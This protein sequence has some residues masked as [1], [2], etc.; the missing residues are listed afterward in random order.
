M[1]RFLAAVALVLAACA[2]DPMPP[3]E[4]SASP[5]QPVAERSEDVRAPGA[6]AE[7]FTSEGCSSCPP[8]DA[9]LSELA[10]RD[11]VI[12]LSFHV[13]YWNDLG[14]R[15]PYSRDA[16]SERQRA[17]A[18]TLDGRVYTPQLVVDGTEGFVGSRRMQAN[19]A[20]NT[21]LS[22]TDQVGITL[23]VQPED[24][25]LRASYTVGSAP[26]EAVL[27]LALVQRTGEQAVARGENRGRTLHHTNIV[28]TFD[29]VEATSGFRVLTLPEGLSP[30][31]VRVVAYVQEGRVGPILGATIAPA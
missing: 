14:W 15:D 4:P 5:T 9:L 16:F 29:T 25:G 13:D 12:A 2:A 26:D 24:E 23:T 19:Q 28:R 17:Y 3:L 1:T 21:A 6:V 27:H 7:L 22:E 18:R 8:A 11:G 10:E 30:D 20:I 31:D